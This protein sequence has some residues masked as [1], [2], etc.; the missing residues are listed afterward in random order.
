M[1][2][3]LFKLQPLHWSALALASAIAP[4]MG[5]LPL[6]E[7]A[8]IVMLVLTKLTLN[9]LKLSMPRWLL[10][11]LC[12]ILTIAIW[13]DFGTISGRGPGIALLVVML[14]LKF[15]EGQQYR[16]HMLVIFLSYFVIATRLL[17]DQNLLLAVY[18]VSAVW[19]CT[20]ALSS[21]QFNNGLMQR[22]RLCLR[23]ILE[24]IP[25][26]LLLFLLFPRMPG[27]LWGFHEQV[28]SGTSGLS[29]SMTPGRI[30]Q[31]T[32]NPSVAFRV[33]FDTSPPLH[34]Q[35]YWRGPVLSIFDG[36]TWRMGAPP[37]SNAAV[38][39]QVWGSAI[40]YT[41]TMEPHH[42]DWVFGLEMVLEAAPKTK[43]NTE[44]Q[45]LSEQPINTLRQFK[46]KSF[47][48]YR[49]QTHLSEQQRQYYLR[50]PQ[51]SNTRTL[52]LGQQLAQEALNQNEKV[53]NGLGFYLQQPFRYTLQ[54]PLLGLHAMDEFLFETQAGFC[55]HFAGSFTLM[56]RAAGVPARVVT[57]YLG[58]EMNSLGE[59]MIVRQS[60]AHAWVE[61]WLED[62]GWLRIDPTATVSPERVES[63]L[64]AAF[65]DSGQLPLMTSFDAGFIR[66]IGLAWDAI[67][68]GWNQ[69]VLGYGKKRQLE[70]FRTLGFD[71][72]S[73]IKPVLLLIASMGVLL[74]IFAVLPS[75]L[76]RK[77][78]KFKWQ[79]YYAIFCRK[80]R[81]A[82]LNKSGYSGAKEFS[83]QAQQRFPNHA[84]KIALI[85][86][87]YMQ[88]EYGPVFDNKRLQNLKIAVLGLRI[89]R[90]DA[91]V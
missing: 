24:A 72:H 84:K 64:S 74:L 28:Q 42:R 66:D 1:N 48:N 5:W 14:G 44:L 16:D 3:N 58:G 89:K 10:V 53:S 37:T 7:T 19:L 85:S 86:D 83:N 13:L 59:Y 55:E 88:L 71:S 63:G 81:R 80:L 35:L 21:L 32:K 26:T 56:M 57:G 49:L 34:K 73:L 75:Y 18:L 47:Q 20:L 22:S 65:P 91:C 52:A 69:W 15:V 87:L 25:L 54:P 27:P 43:L 60:D 79:E 17:I 36:E 68:N 33:K 23:L 70:L 29:D 8:S 40:G 76:L 4:H 50:Y 39:S 67:N 41:V 62:S 82:G 61:V 9:H 51:H 46:L 90:R 30:S 6:W 31:L 45:L 77:K 38:N 12:L 78:Y 11:G 2:P